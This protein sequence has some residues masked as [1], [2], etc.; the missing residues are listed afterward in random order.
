MAA[1][2]RGNPARWWKSR[3][4]GGASRSPR[5]LFVSPFRRWSSTAALSV[6]LLVFLGVWYVTNPARI[7]R[8][9]EVLLSR[10]LGG[11]VKVRTGH[12]SFSGTLILS[13]VEVGAADAGGGKSVQ[14]ADEAPIFSA[15]Q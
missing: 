6:L 4:C 2:A 9:S 10:V 12:L 7:S 1:Y 5:L 14:A 15:E 3:S 13:G 8:L 11:R